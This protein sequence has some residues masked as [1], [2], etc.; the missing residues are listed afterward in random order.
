LERSEEL[1]DAMFEELEVT[2]TKDNQISHDKIPDE[3]E[4]DDEIAKALQQSQEIAEKIL[5]ENLEE[6]SINEDAMESPRE[7]MENIKPKKLNNSDIWGDKDKNI[8]GFDSLLLIS[9]DLQSKGLNLF[10]IIF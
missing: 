5:H 1:I 2:S 9:K 10:F 4:L 8:G 6:S 3:D 7:E